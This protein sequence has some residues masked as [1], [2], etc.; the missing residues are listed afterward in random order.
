MLMQDAGTILQ[1]AV[2][3]LARRDYSVQQLRAKLENQ[4]VEVPESVFETL[5][6]KRFLNDRRYAE[7][8]M[9]RRPNRGP[10]RLREE[11]VARG[12]EPQLI[13]EILART[14][15]PSLRDVVN[16]KM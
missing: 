2:K 10:A 9:A 8:Y 3:L 14:E 4:F 5:I 13:E 16:A 7:N 6:A 11:L 15:R 12:V 1:Y